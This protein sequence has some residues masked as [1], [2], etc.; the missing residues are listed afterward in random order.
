MADDNT[1]DTSA[2]TAVRRLQPSS[3][4]WPNKTKEQVE[5]NPKVHLSNLR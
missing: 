5:L 4:G 1:D 2:R 3:K